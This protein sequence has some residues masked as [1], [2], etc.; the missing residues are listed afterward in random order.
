MPT[1][2]VVHGVPNGAV[3]DEAQ[4]QGSDDRHALSRT[5]R[6]QY[7]TFT[8]VGAWLVAALFVSGC[9]DRPDAGGRDAAPVF[10]LEATRAIITKQNTQFGVAHIAGD[11]AAIDAMFA[12]DARSYPPGASAAIGIEAIHALT[13]D[14]LKAGVTEF[15]EET[16]SFYGNAEY[17]ID[18][19][20][21]LL[22]YG[23]GITERGKYVNVWKQVNGQWRIQSNIWNADAP[24]STSKEHLP[25]AP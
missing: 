22:T 21:Y 11:V 14:F 2:I 7:R 23:R 8:H 4:K 5:T 9:S 17:V 13:V 6:A 3:R 10:D 12:P 19:G 16:A 1:T 18:E 20:S 15:R 25:G 24:D